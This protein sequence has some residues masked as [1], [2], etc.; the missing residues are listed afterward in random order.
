MVDS[1]HWIKKG[2]PVVN[3]TNLE[4]VFIVDHIVFKSKRI[5]VN[6]EEKKNV[7]HIVGVKCYYIDDNNEKIN[8]VFHSKELVPVDIAKKGILEA[9]NFVNK[10]GVYKIK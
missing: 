7:N 10:E 4:K 3:I 9:C 5:R 2:I 8:M 6:A 1:K